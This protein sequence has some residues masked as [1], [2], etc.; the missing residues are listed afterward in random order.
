MLRLAW[1]ILLDRAARDLFKRTDV[2]MQ[3]ARLG[4][5]FAGYRQEHDHA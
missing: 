2:N 4:S 1:L 3:Y 5:I